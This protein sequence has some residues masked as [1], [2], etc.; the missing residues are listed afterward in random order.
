MVET[1]KENGLNPYAYLKH[2]LEQL[3]NIDLDDSA[4]IDKL[5][6]WYVE[7]PVLCRGGKSGN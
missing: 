7:L 1:A 5:M 2:L 4:K 6:P 3:P